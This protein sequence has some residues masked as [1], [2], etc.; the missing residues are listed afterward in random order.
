MY[1]RKNESMLAQHQMQPNLFQAQNPHQAVI[2]TSG[3]NQGPPHSKKMK[4]TV[5]SNKM[6]P[7]NAQNQQQ[8]L[9][10]G[11]GANGSQK[12]NNKAVVA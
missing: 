1:H 8:V 3:G 12:L 10:Q 6:T 11:K 5:I 7:S 9:A 2:N 4:H